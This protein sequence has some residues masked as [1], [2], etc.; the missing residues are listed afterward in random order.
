MKPI[1]QLLKYG[2][3]LLLQKEINPNESRYILENLLKTDFAGLLMRKN[4]EMDEKTEL[5][6]FDI[7]QERLRG[8]PLQY[9]LHEQYFY[10]YPFF[11]DERVLIPRPET[12]LLVERSIELIKSFHRKGDKELSVLDLCTGSGCIIISL[13]KSVKESMQKLKLHGYGVDISEE[14]LQVAKENALRNQMEEIQWIQSDLFMNLHDQFDLIISNPPYIPKADVKELMLE[15][16]EHEPHLALDG[17]EDGYDFYRRII[18]ESRKFLKPGGVLIFETGYNQKV[19]IMKMME[20]Y[21]Y[22]EVLGF[23]DYSG[24]DRNVQGSWKKVFRGEE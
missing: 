19:E 22:N 14:A 8:K 11:V 13:A 15:V 4:E 7:L 21:G 12:E 24:F 2:E 16:R 1:H 5:L 10:G 17:G 23:D 9:I 6:F 18:E 20:K 3:E